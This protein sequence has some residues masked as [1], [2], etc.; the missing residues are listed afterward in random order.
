MSY[1]YGKS[2]V[3]DGLVFYVDAANDNS[4]PGTGTTWSDLIGGNDGTLTNGPTFNS[5]N[6]GSLVFDGV[7]DYVGGTGISNGG[8]SGTAQS[9]NIWFKVD[10]LDVSGLSQGLFFWDQYQGIAIIDV[11]GQVFIQT[12]GDNS[13]G[14]FSPTPTATANT[15]HNVAFNFN[16]GVSYECWLDGVSFGSVATSDTSN[17]P[18]SSQV[19]SIGSRIDASNNYLDHCNGN[20]A[21]VQAYNRAL[22]SD[23]I[24]QNYNALKNRFV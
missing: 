7:D 10:A 21:I 22:S 1:S 9:Y 2:I 12:D 6:G 19:W 23:E 11:T 5:G 3:T 14:D 24:T 18:A 20:I 17:E 13:I 16:Q 15:W 4:Y 8:G